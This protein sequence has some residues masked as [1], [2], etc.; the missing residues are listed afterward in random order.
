MTYRS[1]SD[2]MQVTVPEGEVD[3]LAVQRFEVIDPDDWTDADKERTDVIS[4]LGYMRMVRDGR[5]CYPGWYTRLVD[6][7]E[8]DEHGHPLVWMSDTTAERA[9]HAEAVAHIQ[10]GK[11]KR[12][13]INGLGLG[14]VL[15]AALT[16]DHVTHVD[17][18]EADERVIKLVGPHYTTDP[19]VNIIHED[20]YEQMGNWSMG[21]RLRWDVAWSDIWSEIVADNLGG[22]D[23]LHNYYR[24]RSAWHGMWCRKE[25]LA[26]RRELRALGID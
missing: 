13:L 9:E 10:M 2:R 6:R 14:M 22:M 23:R 26:Q 16:Y 3:G 25:C 12:V 24:R 8:P 5:E 19:R 17:V 1:Y 18:V 15:Q 20:A 7:N 21:P 4:P 11:A